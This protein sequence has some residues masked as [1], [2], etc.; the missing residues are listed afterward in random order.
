MCNENV[1]KNINL[2]CYYLWLA[3]HYNGH[4]SG[5]DSDDTVNRSK[6]G[7][8]GQQQSE[9]YQESSKQYKHI[10]GDQSK[11]KRKY[12]SSEVSGI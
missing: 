1:L 12:H 4:N 2:F 10:N 6:N 11:S 8:A 5:G 7:K 9:Q 3:I